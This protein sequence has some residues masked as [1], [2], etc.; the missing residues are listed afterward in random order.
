[1]VRNGLPREAIQVI[2]HVMKNLT[3]VVYFCAAGVVLSFA[4]GLYTAIHESHEKASH[5]RP[6]EKIALPATAS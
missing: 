1:M 3:W 4:G 6:I 5:V 2:D